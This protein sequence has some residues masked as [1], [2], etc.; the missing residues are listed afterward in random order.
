MIVRKYVAN[1]QYMF[2]DLVRVKR[3]RIFLSQYLYTVSK[4]GG[5]GVRNLF[6]CV[7]GMQSLAWTAANCNTYVR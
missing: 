1:F 5:E 6:V 2:F 4:E 3:T 7:K